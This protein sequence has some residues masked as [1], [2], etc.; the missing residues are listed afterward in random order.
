MQYFLEQSRT[1]GKLEEEK[2]SGGYLVQP[3]VQSR[4]NLRVGLLKTLPSLVLKIPKDGDSTATP[5]LILYFLK[6]PGCFY[7][8]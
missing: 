8:R 7:F 6:E 5:A 2:P 3:P 1:L 4:L